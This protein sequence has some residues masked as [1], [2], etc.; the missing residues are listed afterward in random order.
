MTTFDEARPRTGSSEARKR[1]R[2]I[3][4]LMARLMEEKDERKFLVALEENLGITAKHPTTK[5]LFPF[6]GSNTVHVVSQL[7]NPLVLFVL[8]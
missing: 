7:F 3:S 2:E 5:R 4:R 8:R 1:E 6:G